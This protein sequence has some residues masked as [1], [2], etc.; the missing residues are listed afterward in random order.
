MQSAPKAITWSRLEIEP[1]DFIDVDVAILDRAFEIRCDLRRAQRRFARHQRFTA[2]MS[3]QPSPI[4]EMV[5]PCEPSLRLF[6]GSSRNTPIAGDLHCV[7]GSGLRS[8]G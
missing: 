4:S 7:G 6:I 1:P 2:L 5:R 3:M 8:A